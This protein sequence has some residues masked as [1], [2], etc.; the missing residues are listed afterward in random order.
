M[1]LEPVYME[2]FDHVPAEKQGR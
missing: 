1:I 2:G